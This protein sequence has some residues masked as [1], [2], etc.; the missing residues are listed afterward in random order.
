V[1]DIL[2]FS[3]TDWD[4]PWGSRQQV[5][6]RFARRGYRVLFIEQ[7]AGLEHLLR[8]PDLRRNRFRRWR[9]GLYTVADNLWIASPPP[10]FPGR[11]YS[12]TINHINQKLMVAWT[13][14]LLPRIQF[15]PAILWVYN[16]EVWPLI[17]RFGERLSIYH[18]VEEFAA[19]TAGLKR[20]TISALEAK[21]LREADL[22]IF[23]AMINYINKRFLNPRSYRISHGADTVLFGRALDPALPP[24]PAIAAIPHPIAGFL[25]NIT[26]RFDV[27]L[28]VEV[29]H[30]LPD[31]QF[32]FVGQVYPQSVDISPLQRLPNTHF[33]GKYPFV[34]TP[35]LVKGMDVCLLP[36][37]D[38][39]RGRY[40]SPLKLYEYLAAGKPV[41]SSRQP[42]AREFGDVVYL[43]ATPADFVEQITRALADDG[44]ERRQQRLAIAGQHSWDLRVDEMERVMRGLLET[45]GD[46]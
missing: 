6:L 14:S 36:N 39:E 10:L 45:Q 4:G 42:E 11:Y 37:V 16:P 15:T 7:P 13:K 17:G 26:D 25:G 32:V 41:V 20:Q 46:G 24:H 34:E 29:V 21:L 43:A 1:C 5:M 31:W 23:S 33:L 22:I 44:P 28:L 27:S 38:D 8:Y 30:R 12:Q 2:C 18:C 40:R 9:E 3:T 19:G 35:A